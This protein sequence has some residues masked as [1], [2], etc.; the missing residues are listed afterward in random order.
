[1]QQLSLPL[2]LEPGFVTH[3][4]KHLLP[5]VCNKNIRDDYDHAMC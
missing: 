3:L 4:A 5:T 1:M 2:K